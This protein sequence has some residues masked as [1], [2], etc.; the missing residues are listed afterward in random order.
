MG[1]AGGAASPVEP[2]FPPRFRSLAGTA[3]QTLRWA[4]LEEPDGLEGGWG[5]GERDGRHKQ[6]LEVARKMV[7]GAYVSDS[8]GV[9]VD[10]VQWWIGYGF[11]ENRRKDD[12]K[13]FGLSHCSKSEHSCFLSW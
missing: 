11:E 9:T 2:C 5:P 1:S 10:W 13:L 12:F 7:R 3:V 6:G 8:C 4:S